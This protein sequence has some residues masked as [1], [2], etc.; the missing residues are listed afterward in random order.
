MSRQEWMVSTTQGTAC[1]QGY[2]FQYGVIGVSHCLSC[3][4][5][6]TICVSHCVSLSACLTVSHSHY[7]VQ[8]SRVTHWLALGNLVY[9][10]V[11]TKLW[12]LLLNINLNMTTLLHII[13]VSQLMSVSVNLCLHR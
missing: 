5:Q 6:L 12:S 2:V 4:L 1:L 3:T 7:H 10:T 8:F 11:G 9:Q 13:M